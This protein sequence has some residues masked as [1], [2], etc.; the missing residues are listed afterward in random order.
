MAETTYLGYA[1][2]R[3]GSP[4]PAGFGISV[5]STRISSDQDVFDGG[6]FKVVGTTKNTGTP[7]MPVKRLV[8]L[9]DGLTGRLLRAQWSNATT[10]IYRFERIRKGVFFVTSEDYTGLYNGVIATGVASE[11][12]L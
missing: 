7:N 12:M 4:P 6:N 10:G 3:L 5:A 8:R 11:P 1:N 9:Y 2:C